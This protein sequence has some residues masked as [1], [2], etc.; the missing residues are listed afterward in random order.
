MQQLTVHRQNLQRGRHT[1]IARAC[2]AKCIVAVVHKGKIALRCAGHSG[3]LRV[4]QS[5]SC[6]EIGYAVAKARS[7]TIIKTSALYD[8]IANGSYTACCALCF[9]VLQNRSKHTRKCRRRIGSA[10]A[11]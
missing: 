7:W 4:E 5:V 9:V 8:G 1:A 11:L 6:F 10:I 3:E 2:Y